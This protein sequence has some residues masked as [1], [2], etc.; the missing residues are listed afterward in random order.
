MHSLGQTKIRILPRLRLPGPVITQL[1]G[2][3]APEMI[4]TIPTDANGGSSGQGARYIGMELTS[5]TQI[6]EFRATNG[7]ADVQPLMLDTDDDGIDD[8]LCWTTWY[9]SSWTDR[10]GMIGCHDV[11]Q[12]PPSKDWSRIMNRGSGN[13]N[14]E[15][16][17]S[18]P[19]AL[20]VNGDAVDEIIVPFGR[21]LFAFD[22]ET[23]AQTDVS[24]NWESALSLPHRTWASPAVSDVDGDGFIDIL[25]GDVLVS[26]RLP[27]FA[28][29]Q[30]NRGLTFNPVDPDPGDLVTV[31]GQL[32]NFGVT[33]GDAPLDISITLNNVEILRERIENTEPISPSG[34]GGPI[35]VSTTFTAELGLHDLVMTID[36]NGNITESQEDNNQFRTEIAILAPYV[37][38]IDIPSETTRIIPGNTSD[39][40]IVLT[41]TGSRESDW[42]LS[43]T[44]YLNQGWSF[45]IDQQQ[46]TTFTLQPNLPQIVSF[47]AFVPETALGD[48]SGYVNLTPNQ[49]RKYIH[50][51]ASNNTNRSFAYPRYFY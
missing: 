2:D 15:I 5:T 22:G 23:G 34:E 8:R 37:A 30:D 1:D 13:D 51:L 45:S 44:E 25:I 31:T 21:R 24:T 11:S 28:P 33:D 42:S 49:F 6:F 40:D 10:E 26:Q 14:D 4:L 39:V 36:V 12:S 50:N 27:D 19:I 46:S 41:G 7:Y 35:T 47:S 43:W 16:A 32:A 48:E 20:D 38:R 18:S 17:V 29:L 9:A 3:S